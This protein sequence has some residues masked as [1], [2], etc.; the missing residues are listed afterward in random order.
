MSK[1]QLLL[2]C[3]LFVGLI[4]QAQVDGPQSIFYYQEG[5][6]LLLEGKVKKAKKSFER[7]VDAN[8]NFA[9]AYRG[10]A[11]CY[12]DELAYEKAIDAYEKVVSLDSLFARNVYYHLGLLYYKK[13]ENKAALKCFETFDMMLEVPKEEEPARWALEWQEDYKMKIDNHIKACEIALDSTAFVNVTEVYNLDDVINT[14]ANEYFPYLANDQR[15]LFFSRRADDKDDEDLYYSY[16]RDEDW[17]LPGKVKKINTNKNEGMSTFVRDGRTMFFTVCGRKE[18]I[19]G[20]DIWQADVRGSEV[21]DVEPIVGFPNSEKWESEANVNC[22][23]TLLIFASNRPGGVGGTDLW[24]SRKIP[25]TDRWDEPRNLGIKINTPF[26]EEAPFITNDGKT[27]YFSSTGHL[28]LGEQDIFVSWWD[29]K[30]D[31]WN[32]PI[33]LGP[34]VNSPHRELGFFLSADGMTGY[35]ASDRP[36]GYG[37][38]DIYKFK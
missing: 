19:G 3:L 11:L 32:T 35:F 31:S 9:A 15:L 18:V 21:L 37:G 6:Q 25:G 36:E 14:A 5:E 34:P 7:A 26:N 16:Y 27:L 2:A 4:G 29:E 28:G 33:N 12:E 13:G 38:M 10:L 1:K 17:V 20:C 23:G 30:T 24:M 8:K 22:D